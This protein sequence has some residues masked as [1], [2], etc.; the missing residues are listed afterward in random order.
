MKDCTFQYV[1]NKLKGM[2]IEAPSMISTAEDGDIP[3]SEL[4]AGMVF[5]V[6]VGEAV[7]ADG[8]VVKGKSTID[9][10]SITGEALPISKEKGSK[11]LAG[12]VLQG[13]FLTV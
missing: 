5:I 3:A 9:E 8:I 13:G 6:R 12:S 10:S 4:R 7:P 1:D 2:V 11:V